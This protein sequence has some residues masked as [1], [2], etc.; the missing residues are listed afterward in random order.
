MNKKY[1]IDRVKSDLRN[2]IYELMTHKGYHTLEKELTE[3]LLNKHDVYCSLRAFMVRDDISL[4]ERQAKRTLYSY[5][6]YKKMNER[7]GGFHFDRFKSFTAGDM[8]NDLLNEMLERYKFDD[9][10]SGYSSFESLAAEEPFFDFS[11]SKQHKNLE[12]TIAMALKKNT[13]IPSVS[14]AIAQDIVDGLQL[15]ENYT[16]IQIENSAREQIFDFSS[17]VVSEYVSL[18]RV[19]VVADG[20]PCTAMLKRCAPASKQFSFLLTNFGS[21]IRGNNI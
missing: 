2:D 1:I 16:Y 9:F 14:N 7:L 12:D 15:T 18:K 19:N 20:I 3:N 5:L 17:E 4:R 11:H 13:V 10:L 6:I 8:Q 21:C